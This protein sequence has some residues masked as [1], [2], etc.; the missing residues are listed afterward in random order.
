MK[1]IKVAKGIYWVEIPEEDLYI[2]CGCPADSVKHLAKRGLIVETEKDGVSYETGPNAILLSDVPIQKG[3]FSNLA[4]FPVLQMLYRQGMILPGHPNNFGIKPM[5]IGLEEQVM[6]QA[7]YIYIGNYGLT[8]IDEIVQAGISPDKAQEMMRMKLKF[9]FDNIR[10]TEDL[11]DIRVIDQ[12][13]IELKNG[14]MLNRKGLNLFELTYKGESVKVNLNLS[15]NDK[16][17]SPYHLGSFRTHR[18][19]FSIT[20]IGDGDGWDVNRGAMSSLI[21]F[22]GKIYLIDAGPNIQHTLTALGISVS[23]IEGIFHS[24]AHDDHFGGL[25]TLTRS[26]HMIKYYAPPL[27]RK[28]VVK[29]LSALMSI[30][31]KMFTKYFEVIDLEFDKWNDIDGLEVRPVFSPHPVETGILFFRTLWKGGYKTYAHFADIIAFDVLEGMITDDPSKSGVTRAF[32]E[33]IKDVLLTPVDLKKIDNSGG[34]IHGTAGDFSNDTSGKIFLS[35]SAKPLSNF[36][37]EIGSN[38]SFGTDD[39]LI[40]SSQD[41]TMRSAFIYAN[42]YYPSVPQHQLRMLLNCPIVAFNS[43]T[44][45]IKKDTHTEDV[46]LILT[47][48]LEN[49]DSK[50]GTNNVLSVGSMIGEYPIVMNI[51]S[52]GTYRAASYI[53]ALKISGDLFIEFV[54]KNNLRE[55][56]IETYKNRELLQRSWLFGE[57][58]SYP[59]QD[60]IAREMTSDSYQAGKEIPISGN[61]E[62]VMLEDGELR[63]QSGDYI[64]DLQNPGDFVGE[65]SIIF[66]TAKS[67]QIY[68]A[69]QSNIKRIPGQVLQ[70]IPIVQWK[71][72][73]TLDIRRRFPPAAPSDLSAVTSG[74]TINLSWKDKSRNE[75][76]FKVMRK[77]EFLDMY[78][79]IATIP[80]D[81]TTFGDKVTKTGTYRY[82]VVSTN[83]VGDSPGSNVVEV[84]ISE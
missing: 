1:K 29:K 49:I 57:I 26:D 58:V 42:S 45:L 77:D 44:I 33:K 65:E 48:V 53:K 84:T 15:A 3:D 7:Q 8:T 4:E 79:K 21:I 50:I 80:A 81:I 34:L 38:A 17:E 18:E 11:L 47:G 23:E 69:K 82:I 75:T 67:F 55:T 59:I 30:E 54:E 27:V 61:P 10:K 78:Q 68:A 35:H 22:Q 66:K 6:A 37:K 14:V 74:L 41:Y 16:Y 13:I 36:H 32:F 9:A 28:S 19:Y 71:L 56:I 5:L 73:E 70:D 46:F 64:F 25:T 31:E 40:P 12:D 83:E 60:L 72:L 43:G 76:G 63:M 62:L 2:L 52:Q 24:H 51:P 20:H 39:V